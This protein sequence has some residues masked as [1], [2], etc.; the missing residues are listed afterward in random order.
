MAKANTANLPALAESFAIMNFTPG[1]IAEV[2][3]ENFGGKQI[4]MLDLERIK[5]PGGGGLAWTVEAA[6]GEDAVKHLDGVLILRRDQRLYYARKFGDGDRGPPDCYSLDLER[7]VGDPG[8]SCAA[9]PLARY[10]TSVRQDG[11]PGRGQ[12]CRQMNML[13]MLRPDAL[14]PS[15]VAVPPSSL[16]HIAAYMRRLASS[17]LTYYRVM[18]RLGLA[19]TRSADGIDYSQIVPERIGDVPEGLLMRVNAMRDSLNAIRTP[20]T[21]YDPETGEMR[22]AA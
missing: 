13:F 15:V 7:G 9:C 12:A 16:K 1:D 19:K 21:D 17:G 20:I 18:T 8:G 11:S 4:G 22:E 2:M 6:E 14:I 3:R 10:G 5:V